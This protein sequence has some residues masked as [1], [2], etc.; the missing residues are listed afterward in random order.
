MSDRV[1]P[2][3]DAHDPEFNSLVERL[4]AHAGAYASERPGM[5]DRVFIAS[6]AE[7]GASAPVAVIGSTASLRWSSWRA[8]AAVVALAVSAPLVWRAM[9]PAVTPSDVS[10]VRLGARIAELAPA[11]RSEWLLVALVDDEAALHGASAWGGGSMRD[12][13]AIALTRGSSADLVT[14]ELEDLLLDDPSADE[15]GR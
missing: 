7:L 1:P 10:T 4:G 6:R 2:S 8:V 9:T 3:S 5:A 11:S 14:I 15:A 12:A 13:D